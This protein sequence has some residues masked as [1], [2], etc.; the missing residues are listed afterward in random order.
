MIELLPPKI[1]LHVTELL[2]PGNMD[3]K[4]LSATL[5]ARHADG[6][7]IPDQGAMRATQ[8]HPH[9]VDSMTR[10]CPRHN[11]ET[12][13]FYCHDHRV[14]VCSV[15]V[16]LEHTK[17]CHVDCSQESNDHKVT[18]E[19]M[20]NLLKK[21]TA[22]KTQ[23][24]KDASKSNDSLKHCLL[25]VKRYREEMNQRIDVLEREV[26]N[27][28]KALQHENNKQAKAIEALCEDVTKMVKI[29]LDTI[30]QLNT[31]REGNAERLFMKVKQAQD[32]V[33]DYENDIRSMSENSSREYQFIPSKAINDVLQHEKMIGDISKKLDIGTSPPTKANHPHSDAPAGNTTTSFL[34]EIGVK[35]SREED[36]CYITG[37]TMVSPGRLVLIDRNKNCVKLVDVNQGA[38]TSQLV[39]GKKS[40]DEPWD[41]AA[42]ASSQVAVTQPDR[43]H[44]QFISVSDKLKMKHTINTEGQCYGICYYQDKL[45]VTFS[46]PR[47][48]E[49][50]DMKGKV[51]KRFT[52]DTTRANIFHD[53]AYVQANDT[54]IFVSD[55]GISEIIKLNWQGE[56][57]G[58]FGRLETP[59][60]LGMLG[61]GSLLV[62]D[63]DINTIHRVSGD[64]KASS[65]FLQG[66]TC[67]CAVYV[68]DKERKLYISRCTPDGQYNNSIL[69]F[70]I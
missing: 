39:L 14:S 37:M 12:I 49:V 59:T 38:T 2:K 16:A 54:S 61:D 57:T 46:T 51:M 41:I 64:C 10:T 15:C 3:R 56:I 26:E 8:R 58:R 24:S 35:A 21:C 65:V 9:Q 40:K 19:R 66:M 5:P 63:R 53:P 44:I 11:N 4:L 62:C 1:I 69:A 6:G 45:V 52:P 60:G 18:M 47:K 48:L 68:D 36:T 28:I 50:L 29:T 23:A 33:Q 22:L 34:T 43:Q 32:Q 17:P 7:Y 20:D 42:T 55:V 25:E 70:N 31:S 67:P 13:K 27:K 30:K